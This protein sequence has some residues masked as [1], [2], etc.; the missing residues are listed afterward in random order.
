M[1]YISMST[2]TTKQTNM[3]DE[4]LTISICPRIPDTKIRKLFGLFLASWI[5]FCCKWCFGLS[6]AAG[7]S[8]NSMLIAAK[9]CR[10]WPARW[11][12]YPVSVHCTRSLYQIPG[13]RGKFYCTRCQNFL[14]LL[15]P[16]I[17]EKCMWSTLFKYKRVLLE[18]PGCQNPV[19]SFSAVIHLSLVPPF[20]SG[21]PSLYQIPRYPFYITLVL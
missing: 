12:Q 9:Y 8:P 3:M 10:S 14:F 11:Y 19:P 4:R 16:F 7:F 17:L 21:I 6:S 1:K 18:I 5:A 20:C 15:Y 2:R 13:H